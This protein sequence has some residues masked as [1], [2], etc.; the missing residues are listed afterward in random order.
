M[1]HTLREISGLPQE[2]ARL[3]RSALIMIDC[4]NTYMQGVMRLEGVEAALDEASKLLELARGAGTPNLHI[5]HDAGAGTPYSPESLKIGGI[6][7]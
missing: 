7:S 4:Q 5:Q 6:A 1:P 2:P 3:D